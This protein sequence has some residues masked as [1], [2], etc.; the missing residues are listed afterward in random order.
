MTPFETGDLLGRFPYVR[1][2]EGAKPLV[3]FPGVGDAMFDGDY[4]PPSAWVLRRYF[5]RFVD[6]YAVYVVSRPRGLPEGETIE[7]MAADYADALE[8]ELGPAD[9]LG[10]S[11]GGMIGQ[12]FAADHPDLVDAL[13]LANTGCRVAD[14]AQDTVRRF[15]RYARAHDWGR[16]RA[17]LAAAMFTDWRAVS[18]PP[19]ALTVGRFVLPRPAVPADV[20][21]SLDAILAFDWRDRLDDVDARTLVVGGSDD[22]Y[23][24]EPILEETAAGIPDATLFAFSGATHGA[25]HERKSAFDSRVKAFLRR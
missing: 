25:F 14:A 8:R 2:G 10:I 9:V 19:L 20:R 17:E 24:P 1:V 21:V 13:V 4:P 15:R 12:A 16:I 6:D 22:P 5:R 11:M 23:F 3:V 7:G 18:Y